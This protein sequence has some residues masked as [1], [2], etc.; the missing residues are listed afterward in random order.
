MF[1]AATA[2]AAAA[3]FA[4]LS[5]DG[6]NSVESCVSAASDPVPARELSAAVLKASGDK[7]ESG[8]TSISGN[9]IQE[10]EILIEQINNGAGKK[11][12]AGKKEMKV[13][14]KPI[15]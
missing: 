11:K 7:L 4:L 9:T 10:R 6:D 2:A 8:I 3:D 12:L 14:K 1:A 13:E 5:A 15:P